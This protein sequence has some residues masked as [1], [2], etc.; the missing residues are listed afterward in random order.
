[1]QMKVALVLKCELLIFFF[2]I[3]CAS[4]AGQ[5]IFSCAD[6]AYDTESEP[7]ILKSKY[8]FMQIFG[9]VSYR[10]TNLFKKNYRGGVGWTESRLF[11]P[12]LRQPSETSLPLPEP[13]LKGILKV[14]TNIDWENRWDYGM[15]IEWRPLSNASMLEETAFNWTRHLRFYVEYLNGN[16]LQNQEDWIWRPNDDFRIGSELYRECNLYN[17]DKYWGEIW[18]DYSWRKTNFFINDFKTWTFALVPKWGVKLFP[19]KEFAIMPYITGEIAVTGRK[20]FWQNRALLGAGVRVMPFRWH[21][22]VFG[23][24][25]RGTRIYIE[26]MRVIEYLK[27]EAPQGTSRNDLR[28]GLSFSIYPWK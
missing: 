17:E 15:G 21:G 10:Q 14:L 18:A 13:Y 25:M 28:V 2:L 5:K 1:M 20:E 27:D 12:R 16:Y 23:I 22:G 4:C 11:F 6:T 19:D 9:D 7:G 24:F 8:H 26:G 3:G